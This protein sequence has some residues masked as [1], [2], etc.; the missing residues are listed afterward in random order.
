MAQKLTD[1]LA[2][3]GHKNSL[4]E[5]PQVIEIV[6]H[7]QHRIEELYNCLFDGDAWVR[8]R[9]AD[10][11]EKIC[12]VHP[13]WLLPYID[14]LATDFGASF[15][16]SIQWHMAQIYKQVP[17]TQTQKDVAIQWLTQRIATKDVDWIVA[18]NVMETLAQFAKDGSF[19][20]DQLVSLLKIQQQHKSN[21][22][23]RRA[24]K[25]LATLPS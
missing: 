24:T 23:V 4:G 2:T 21:A 1:M 12:R 20:L 22:V 16:P 17:L 11:F 18:A 19:P 7:D 9:A 13:D 15:Q 8:M 6:L 5:V 25:I 3:G 14:R 10:A